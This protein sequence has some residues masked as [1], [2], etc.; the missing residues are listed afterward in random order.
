MVQTSLLHQSTYLVPDNANRPPLLWLVQMA[1]LQ[2]TSV[3]LLQLGLVQMYRLYKPASRLPDN[4]DRLLRV[5]VV[6]RSVLAD[7]WNRLPQVRLFQMS[8]LHR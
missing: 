3:W 7:N 4:E 5:R 6:Q 2:D 8:L 1:R